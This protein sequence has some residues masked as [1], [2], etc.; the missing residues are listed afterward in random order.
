MALADVV[1]DMV[2]MNV[3]YDLGDKNPA[4]AAKLVKQALKKV[5]QSRKFADMSVENAQIDAPVVGEK[6]EI[7]LETD[8][9]EGEPKSAILVLCGVKSDE[10]PIVLNQESSVNKSAEPF[11]SSQTD[12]FEVCIS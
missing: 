7:D 2:K 10:Q 9:W 4:E 1:N 3:T 5:L 12:S 8:S 11:R 6:W